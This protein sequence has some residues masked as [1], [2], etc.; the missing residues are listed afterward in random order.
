MTENSYLPL[1]SG[2]H[3]FP[4]GSKDKLTIVTSPI[5]TLILAEDQSI[6]S[7]DTSIES[8]HEDEILLAIHVML[9]FWVDAELEESRALGNYLKLR[10]EGFDKE[11]ISQI[12]SSHFQVENTLATL[13]ERYRP[14]F[15]DTTIKA[16]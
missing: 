3:H 6:N 8:G 1:L 7:L 15:E 12:K 10:M 16:K 9:S 11:I 4:F 14:L 2:I 13:E 5:K